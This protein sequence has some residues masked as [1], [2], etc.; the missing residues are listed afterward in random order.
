MALFLIISLLHL[1][2]LHLQSLSFA[3]AL[4]SG[5]KIGEIVDMCQ[6]ID[7]PGSGDALRLQGLPVDPHSESWE[8]K[9]AGGRSRP[10]GKTG[11]LLGLHFAS[12]VSLA[13]LALQA[14]QFGVR[15]KI[16]VK[17]RISGAISISGAERY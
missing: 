4:E 2:Q 15:S 17:C 14:V 5:G 7:Q 8:S 10:D 3:I 12:F 11:I 16:G 13:N 6:P 1:A 9:A